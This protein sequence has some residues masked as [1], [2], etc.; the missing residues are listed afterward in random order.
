MLYVVHKAA[1]EKAHGA[2]S[3]GFSSNGGQ[4]KKELLFSPQITTTVIN[5]YKRT[6][7]L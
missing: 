7:L 5:M 6:D 3:G 2:R 1:K 4:R